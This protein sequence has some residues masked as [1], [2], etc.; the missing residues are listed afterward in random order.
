VGPR[1]CL[2]AVS[3]KELPRPRWESN[4]DRPA[5]NLV[6]VL[7]E[8]SRHFNNI[9]SESNVHVRFQY[10]GL[11]RHRNDFNFV[12]TFNEECIPSRRFVSC[13]AV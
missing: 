9:I 8:L 13:D 7:T 1:T 4:P 5:P 12:L 10:I 2:E 11:L 6:A 3:R